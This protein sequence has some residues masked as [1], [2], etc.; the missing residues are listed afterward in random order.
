MTDAS[1]VTVDFFALVA[2]VFGIFSDDFYA[3]RRAGT[4]GK[5]VPKWFGRLWFFGFAA[6]ML[7]LSLSHFLQPK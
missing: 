7:Y 1:A 6:I 5:R 4:H 3:S 2:A